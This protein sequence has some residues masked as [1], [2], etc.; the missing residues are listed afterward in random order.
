[1][2]VIVWHES[3]AQSRKDFCRPQVLFQP[4]WSYLYVRAWFWTLVLNQE[5]LFFRRS[6]VFIISTKAFHDAFNHVNMTCNLV[7]SLWAG[8]PVWVP[9]TGEARKSVSS[10]LNKWACSQATSFPR[11]FPLNLGGA[12]KFKGKSPGNEV[13]CHRL[14]YG[15]LGG[16]SL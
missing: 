9:R 16:Y 2:T 4:F 3:W 5:W 13:A 8:S 15:T 1:M 12:S 14:N 7:P 6:Y 10:R 11:L